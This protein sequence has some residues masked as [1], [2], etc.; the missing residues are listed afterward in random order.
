MIVGIG[1]D[2]C[3]VARVEKILA[4]PSGTH[5][6]RRVFAPAELE[7]FGVAAIAQKEVQIKDIA[8]TQTQI[9]RIA[10]HFAAKE[11]FL[12][13]MGTGLAGFALAEIAPLRKESGAP[14]YAF[15]GAAADYMQQ[16]NLTAHLSLSHEKEMAMA[17]CVLERVS[18]S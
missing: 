12:K 8:L 17:Y 18:I 15:Y 1:C 3:A 13:A 5:F 11:A 14:Y 10:A 16:Q 4:K 9:Q 6:L 2:L 7:L